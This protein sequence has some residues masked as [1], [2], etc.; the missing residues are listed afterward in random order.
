M[1]FYTAS[2]RE[3]MKL[4]KYYK[5]HIS[6]RISLTLVLHFIGPQGNKQR[7]EQ[8]T[9]LSVSERYA[10]RHVKGVETTIFNVGRNANP[11]L[12]NKRN[13]IDD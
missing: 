6:F 13:I 1:L 5:S 9:I 7:I 11:M 3:E 10:K 8:T 4:Q 12:D 2:Y